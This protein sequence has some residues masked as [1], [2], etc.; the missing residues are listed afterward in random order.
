MT[1][2]TAA[3]SILRLYSDAL[4]VFLVAVRHVHTSRMAIIA[5]TSLGRQGSGLSGT[6]IGLPPV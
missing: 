1:L 5:A 4:I 3:G 6:G 2:P